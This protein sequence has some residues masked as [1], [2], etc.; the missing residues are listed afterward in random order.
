MLVSLR[1][2]EAFVQRTEAITNVSRQ[3][4]KGTG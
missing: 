2:Q 1:P 3:F 4:R